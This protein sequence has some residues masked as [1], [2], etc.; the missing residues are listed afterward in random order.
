MNPVGR[1]VGRLAS[2]VGLTAWSVWL[3]WR[4]TMGSIEAIGV[5]V[6]VLEVAAL[7]VSIVLSAALWSLRSLPDPS[8]TSRSAPLVDVVGD[9]LGVAD[10]ASVDPRGADDTGEVACARRGLQLLDPRSSAVV[11]G[12]SVAVTAWALVAVEGIR[13]MLFVGLLVVVLEPRPVGPVGGVLGGTGAVGVVG[14]AVVGGHGAS[15]LGRTTAPGWSPGGRRD[16][17]A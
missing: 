6:L 14:V 10:L 7:L 9:L 15:S 8:R 4:V 12:T 16:T 13:R 1:W 11:G 5:A 17:A 2:V 3:T